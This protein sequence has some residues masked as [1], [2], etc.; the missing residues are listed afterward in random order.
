[1]N[2]LPVEIVEIIKHMVYESIH[3]QKMSSLL[4][5][6][7]LLAVDIIFMREYNYIC[8]HDYYENMKFSD[9]SHMIQILNSC[10]CESMFCSC[11]RKIVQIIMSK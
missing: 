7:K 9:S 10:K 8:E 5:P 6:I 1:M 2:T 11:R 4:Q 3:W